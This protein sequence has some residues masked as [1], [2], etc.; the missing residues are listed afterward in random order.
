MASKNHNKY[1]WHNGYGRN[2]KTTA[3]YFIGLLNKERKQESGKVQYTGLI[4]EEISPILASCIRDSE[5]LPQDVLSSALTKA[6][7]HPQESGKL[8]GTDFLAAFNAAVAWFNKQAPK[9]YL[10]ATSI[11]GRDTKCLGGLLKYSSRYG[12]KLV[13]SPTTRLRILKERLKCHDHVQKIENLK[14]SND[15]SLEMIT[16]KVTAKTVWEAYQTGKRSLDLI[17]AVLNL[18]IN[19]GSHLR[20]SSGARKPV[21]KILS[22]LLHTIHDENGE[23]QKECFWH[24]DNYPTSISAFDLSKSFEK[25][26][27]HLIDV[28]SML[29]ASKIHSFAEQALLRY[30]S[31]LDRRDWAASFKDL[32]STLEFITNTAHTN[33][34]VTIRRASS[35]YAEPQYATELCKFLRNKRNALIH[36]S[37]EE[38]N[39]EVLVY[40]L[41]R[42]VEPTLVRLIRNSPKLDSME[43][44]GEYL[45]QSRS[46]DV[47]KRSIH[48]KNAAIRFYSSKPK[49]EV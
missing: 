29:R 43:E 28:L 14:R 33:Y 26:E 9:T 39:A 2:G 25:R 35:A 42:V 13:K 31:A 18:Q 24:E 6:L 34:D 22:G 27:K 37:Y 47:L 17:R 16:V 15:N 8:N 5:N 38:P 11:T 1:D 36:S 46:I 4:T 20:I 41:K 40:Q 7:F 10:M 21:N 19:R 45:E 48:I 44:F 3:D 12:A 49:T 23:L 30:N 32:W